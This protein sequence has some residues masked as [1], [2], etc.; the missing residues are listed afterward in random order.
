MSGRLA[1]QCALVTGAGS[2]IGAAV[3]RRLAADGADLVIVDVDADALKALAD[4]IDAY[5]VVADVS[6]ERDVVTGLDLAGDVGRRPHIVCNVAGIGSTTATVDTSVQDWDRVMAVNAR[7]TFLICKHTLPAMVSAGTGSIVNVASVA[8]L[9]GLADR[10]AY[11]ASKGAVIAL[12]RALA[13]DHVAHGVRVNCVC[14]GTV[15][16]PWVDRLVADAVDPGALRATLIA[17][18]PMGR[19]GTADEIAAAVCWLAGDEAAYATGTV[20]VLDGGLTAR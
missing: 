12:T 5:A 16:T 4:E 14:P 8:G 2:G 17:R 20:L 18:Q 1:G 7:G 15:D 6:V 10:A 19:L 11:C 3:S 9:V 13:V